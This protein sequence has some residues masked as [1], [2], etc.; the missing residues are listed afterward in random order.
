MKKAFFAILAVCA[1]SS[2]FA[3]SPL[4]TN[5]VGYEPVTLTN[6]Y[7]PLTL[8]FSNIG[9]FAPMSIQ[10]VVPGQQKGLNSGHS[11]KQADLILVLN[12]N[13]VTT[14]YLSNGRVGDRFV[15]ALSNKWVK[16]GESLPSTDT[17]TNGATFWLVS[18]T[19]TNTPVRL[20]FA[21]QVDLTDAPPLPGIQSKKNR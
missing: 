5:V 10:Q 11:S 2:I 19:A 7:N 21:G 12:T 16:T 13:T 20:T 1:A 15:P 4:G 18:R 6:T 14:Y 8:K 9:R 3:G 17:F